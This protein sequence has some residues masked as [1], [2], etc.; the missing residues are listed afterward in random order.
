MI[1]YCSL[2]Q[3]KSVTDLHYWTI[4]YCDVQ[5]KWM[6]EPLGM[7]R[8]VNEL[9]THLSSLSWDSVKAKVRHYLQLAKTRWTVWDPRRGE[10]AFQVSC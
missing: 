4:L 3:Q 2:Y 9:L 8:H 5:N 6:Y 1:I 7:E 10:F